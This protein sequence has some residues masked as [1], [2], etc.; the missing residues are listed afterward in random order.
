MYLTTV[1][2]SGYAH[3]TDYLQEVA[4]SAVIS[5]EQRYGCKVGTFIT[6]N[7]S[8]MFKMRRQVASDTH[9]NDTNILSY[10]CSAHYVNLLAKDVEYLM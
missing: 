5:T 8:N 3:T 9:T 6:D 1:D 2:T 10:G 4:M 7:A